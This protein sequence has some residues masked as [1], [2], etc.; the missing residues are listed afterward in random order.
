LTAVGAVTGGNEKRMQFNHA[1]LAGPADAKLAWVPQSRKAISLCSDVILTSRNRGAMFRFMVDAVTGKVLI[2]NCLTQ[3]ISPA[4]YRVFTSDS[5]TP[6]SPGFPSPQTN[7]PPQA[8]RSLVTISAL[9]TNASPNGWIDD[10]TNQTVGNNVDAHLD[11]DADDAPDFPRPQGSP[12]RVFDFPLDLS[13]SPSAYRDAAVVQLFY[14]CNFMHDKLYDLGFTEAA[15]NF[16]TDNFGRG[17][18]GGDA[19]LADAQDGSGTDNANMSTPPDG[20]PPRMQMF[21]FTEP[22]PNRDSSLDPEV[23]LHEYTHGLSSRLVGGGVGIGAIQ[24]LGMG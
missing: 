16:Q 24:T 3:S 10:G 19:V 12:E 15:G 8:S 18:L 20:L 11:L 21:V 6:F 9:S 22:Q 14:W 13:L 17:G 4:T 7:Q 1:R 23:I 2:R 5:P